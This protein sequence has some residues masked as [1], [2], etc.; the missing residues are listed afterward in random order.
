MRMAAAIAIAFLLVTAGCGSECYENQNALP[1]AK[2]MVTNPTPQQVSID[3]VEIYGIGC[4]GDS[5]LWEGYS[6]ESIYLPFRVDSDTTRYA[7]HILDTPYIDTVTFCY[8]RSPRFVSEAC[9][10][11]YIYD[12]DTIYNTGLF[13]D[14]VVCP[15]GQITNAAVENLLIYLY[16][17]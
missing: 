11:S 16:N 4:K 9:G 13:I 2:F 1:L 14:S 3:S 10:V 17:E 7:F 8:T 15:G 6:I 12:I 5:I